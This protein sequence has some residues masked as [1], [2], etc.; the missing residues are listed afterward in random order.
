M[1]QRLKREWCLQ[2]I[3][4]SGE[5]DSITSPKEALSNMASGSGWSKDRIESASLPELASYQLQQGEFSKNQ[6]MS[7]S[8]ASWW[9][10]I[11]DQYHLRAFGQSFGSL[12]PSSANIER[13]FSTLKNMQGINSANFSIESLVHDGRSKV[14]IKEW[15]S[16]LQTVGIF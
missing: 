9:S 12:R 6:L 7:E 5:T 8:S 13:A 1:L 3:S 2:R 10:K 14:M 11:N 4:V 16:D 15:W